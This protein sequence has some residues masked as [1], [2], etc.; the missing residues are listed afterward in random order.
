MALGRNQVL[1]IVAIVGI[2][3]LTL[4][5]SGVFNA[6]LKT[7]Y[8]R[9]NVS[10]K[11]AVYLE[12]KNSELRAATSVEGLKTAEPIALRELGSQV[13]QSAEFML[14]IPAD[15]LP[16]GISAI[17]GTFT[18]IGNRISGQL[19]ICRTDEHKAVWQCYVW[20]FSKTADNA[21]ATQAVELPKLEKIALNVSGTPS[22][23]KM[24]VG[25]WAMAANNQVSG[26][27]KDGKAILVQVSVKDASGK[28]VAAK[29]G[30]LSDFGFS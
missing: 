18:R 5:G 2:A 19:G 23:G 13:A 27:L 6:P 7:G 21:G 24:G 15:Q 25:V 26:L 14:P 17:K 9:I 1:V 4:I 8:V 16:D 22:N 12:F 29:T 30:P 11:T 28:E 20:I 10:D 3:A